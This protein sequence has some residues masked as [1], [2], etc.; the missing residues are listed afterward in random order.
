MKKTIV[1][2]GVL[3]VFVLTF[4]GCSLPLPGRS[5]APSGP[6][7]MK[8]IDGGKTY[9]PKVTISEKATI[10]PA[11]ILSFV[12]ETGNANRIT[13][14]TADNGLFATDNAG[15]TW[16]KLNFPPTKSYGLIA[17]R[18][19]P[20]RLYASGVFN[21]R[22]KLYRSDDRGLNWD[23]I[24]TEPSNGTIITA[25]AQD[26][27]DASV[28]YI[29]TSAG[30][31]VK[32]SD[33]GITWKNL[34][35]EASPVLS[36]T[37]DASGSVF[38]VLFSGK[39][40]FLSK[41]GGANIEPVKVK[42]IDTKKD[43]RKSSDSS[44]ITTL[45]GIV[46]LTV[47]PSQS[48]VVYAG[49]KSGLFRSTDFGSSWKEVNIIASSKKFPI[50]GIAIDPKDSNRI[51]YSSALAVYQSTNGGLNWSTYQINANRTAG[52]IRYSPMDSSVVFLGFRMYN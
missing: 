12:F 30:V 17:D 36:F 42:E 3:F 34:K 39:N 44:V 49:T 33:A 25:L 40:I 52:I 22:A 14:G 5:A 9:E 4:S 37:F 21:G 41:D 11:N 45:S 1:S 18:S 2:I 31:I 38:Y 28:I 29:G 15:D 48:G 20:E 43:E 23:E 35:S 51:I 24:Y 47:D 10:A 26:P 7:V 27:R 6:S 16:T 8:S 50:R 46:S 13:I 19:R 32:T